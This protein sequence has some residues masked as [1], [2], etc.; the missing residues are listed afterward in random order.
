MSFGHGL[1]WNEAHAKLNDRQRISPMHFCRSAW[2]RRDTQPCPHPPGQMAEVDDSFA[3]P[4]LDA[5]S[6]SLSISFTDVID[7]DV[8]ETSSVLCTIAEA[9]GK[10][11]LPCNA[12]QFRLWL[13]A[14]QMFRCNPALK[15]FPFHELCTAVMVRFDAYVAMCR[16]IATAFFT[17]AHVAAQTASHVHVLKVNI[18][19][20]ATVPVVGN[21]LSFGASSSGVLV[22]GRP[23]G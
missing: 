11:P 10:A 23:N 1:C 9:G 19:V 22:G 4:S 12:S 16:H 2:Q 20:P 21:Q 6:G 18:N 3:H 13:T 8:V 5:S 17:H 7:P 14:K 15:R